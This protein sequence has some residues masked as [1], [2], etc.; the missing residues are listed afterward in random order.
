MTMNMT[1]DGELEVLCASRFNTWTTV[2]LAL[3]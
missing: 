3:Y 1:L 2:I